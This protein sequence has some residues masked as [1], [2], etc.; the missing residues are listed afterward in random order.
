MVAL[1]DLPVRMSVRDF[2]TWEPG[3]VPVAELYARTGL[4]A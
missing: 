3:R 2:L 4:A 1:P